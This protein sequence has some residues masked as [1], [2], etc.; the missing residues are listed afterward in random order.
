MSAQT[1]IT[2][3]NDRIWM[4]TPYAL[5]EV[6]ELSDRDFD[7]DTKRWHSP[8]TN[9]MA[10]EIHNKLATGPGV[11]V[12]NAFRVLV[13]AAQSARKLETMAMTATD[14]PDIPGATTAWLHQRQAFHFAKSLN[15]VMLGMDMGTGKSKVAIAL[16]E[17]WQAMFVVILGPRRALPVWPKQF[18]VHAEREWNVIVPPLTAPVQKRAAYIEREMLLGLADGLPMAVCINYES[19]WRDQMAA[20]LKHTRWNVMIGDE[21]HRTKA[22]G[23]KASRFL[24]GLRKKSDRA[25]FLTGT[26]MPHSP[27]DIYAQYR[28]LDTSIFGTSFS[29]FRARYAIMG[30]YEGR[31]VIGYQNM[32]ELE[33]KVGSIAFFC[34]SDEVLDLP[35]YHH[36]QE[37]CE[38]EP[39]ARRAYNSMDEDFVAVIKD[40]DERGVPIIA[41]NALVKLLRLQ[42]LTGGWLRDDNEVYHR[43]STAKQELL[44]DVIEDIDVKEPLVIF[45]RFQ[46]DLD[47]IIEACTKQGRKVAE[48][49]GR[50][51]ESDVPQHLLEGRVTF[52]G[53]QL[54][55]TLRPGKTEYGLTVDA[56][57]REDIDVI[58]VQ[59]QAGGV[60]IDLTRSRYGIYYSMGYSLGDY[61]QSLKRVH[62]PGQTRPTTYIHLVAAGTKDEEVYNALSERKAVVEA[63]IQ[64]ARKRDD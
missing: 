12:D 22:P 14:L 44:S 18:R 63:L 61:E 29:R 53:R 45:G 38:L 11:I 32:D 47:A 43:V 31:Q 34:K 19:A 55:S 39:A 42:Q 58:A 26:P 62:R 20:M 23:G 4:R 46:N 7:W 9:S 50:V 35:P 41:D 60:G 59:L 64:N 21:S 49:S 33:R 54:K 6:Q 40:S 57:M 13:S 24:Q 48:L 3:A 16:C 2:V 37:L 25:I 36:T 56:T 27:L 51:K 5:K 10:L 28:A 52:E 17:E 8:A 1:F 30:G 15:A